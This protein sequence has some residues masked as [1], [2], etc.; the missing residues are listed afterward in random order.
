MRGG[1][2]GRPATM[3]RFGVAL[4][5]L[6]VGLL[7]LGWPAPAPAQERDEARPPAGEL[8]QEPAMAV[9]PKQF[10][11]ALTGGA[12]AWDA[13]PGRGSLGDGPLVGIDIERGIGSYLAFR[14][15]GGF[16]RTT[17]AND[18][19]STEVNQYLLDLVASARLAVGPL[20]RAGVVPFGTIGLGSV[21]HDPE[22][23]ELVTKS[24]SAVAFGAG[25]DADL[26]STFGVRAEWRRYA[27]DAEDLFDPM[28]RTGEVRTADR[29]YGSVYVKL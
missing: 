1:R 26:G 21:V 23:G 16:A 27:V 9:A 20:G 25:L 6:A 11:L 8:L 28:D 14:L 5:A 2:A 10:R 4:V 12:L 3:P 22:L 29:F 7:G 19:A 17:A 13:A 15:S 18:T 24:Q